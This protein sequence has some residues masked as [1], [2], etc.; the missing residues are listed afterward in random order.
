VFGPMDQ[1]ESVTTTI[2]TKQVQP[3]KIL[4]PRKAQKTR[5][6]Q[7]DARMSGV[8]RL[9]SFHIQATIVLFVT[10][11]FFVMSCVF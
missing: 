2:S 7:Q 11:V 5:K 3:G 8:T 4:C 10:F 9:V 1:R 6:I